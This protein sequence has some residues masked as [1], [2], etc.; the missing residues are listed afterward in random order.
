M[1]L[2]DDILNKPTTIREWL[3]PQFD[4]S[5]WQ[6]IVRLLRAPYRRWFYPNG[7]AWFAQRISLVNLIMALDKC[8]AIE[9]EAKQKILDCARLKSWL[10]GF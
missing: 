9:A 1:N 7:P 2:F 4:V 10:N 5:I 3:N 8:S 6:V